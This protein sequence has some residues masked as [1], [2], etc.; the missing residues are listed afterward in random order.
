RQA[1]H[2]D[3]EI[4]TFYAE[5]QKRFRAI[6]GVRSVSLS[7]NPLIANR[8]SATI[9]A[10]SGTPERQNP[11]VLTVGPGFFTTLQI[12]L[13]RGREMDDHDRPSLNPV[14]VVNEAFAKAAFGD[15]N[16]LGQHL[17]LPLD[18]VAKREIE[19]VGVSTNAHYRALQGD[20]R[21]TVYRKRLRNPSCSR[22]RTP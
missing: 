16:P 19:I 11:L 5:L 17:N 3:P 12:P 9:V 22:G 14:A 7:D 4:Y 21:P 6:P 13:L 1:G 15:Q 10:V 20:V 18:P 2:K 8:A